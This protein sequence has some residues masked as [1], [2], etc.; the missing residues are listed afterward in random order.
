MLKWRSKHLRAFFF[1][2]FFYLPTPQH[3]PPTP[4]F[5]IFLFSP[6]SAA[7]KKKSPLR[8]SRPRQKRDTRSNHKPKPRSQTPLNSKQTSSV[9]SDGLL[10]EQAAVDLMWKN[11][12]TGRLEEGWMLFETLVGTETKTLSPL[13]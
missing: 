2:F 8:S 3:P 10:T 6:S 11:K 7:K 4:F 9:S 13:Q 5:F 1:F 12:N